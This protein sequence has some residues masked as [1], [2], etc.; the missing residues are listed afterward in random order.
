M[1]S[2]IRKGYVTIDLQPIHP[3]NTFPDHD[4]AVNVIARTV[5]GQCFL[6]QVRRLGRQSWMHWKD[7]VA[8]QETA[9]ESTSQPIP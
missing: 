7:V 9:P 3:G 5:D 6:A 4:E 1:A 2:S 8:W